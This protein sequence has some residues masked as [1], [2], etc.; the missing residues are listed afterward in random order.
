MGILVIH[1]KTDAAW[2]EELHVGID[3]SI[4]L[5]TCSQVSIPVG[6]NRDVYKLVAN[7]KEHGFLCWLVTMAEMQLFPA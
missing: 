2:I 3:G 7:P 6:I 5:L 4:N 1:R